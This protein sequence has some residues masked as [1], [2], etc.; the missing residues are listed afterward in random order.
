MA[1]AARPGLGARI[2]AA[3]ASERPTVVLEA[4]RRAGRAVYEE[5][6]HAERVGQER[7]V[8]GTNAWDCSPAVASRLVATHNALVLQ[9]LGEELLDAEYRADPGT[10]GYV[11]DPVFAQVWWWFSAVPRWLARARQARQNPDY[12]LRDEVQL[13]VDLPPWQPDHDTINLFVA[14]ALAVVPR[15]RQHAGY[16]VYALD[17]AS[18]P[19]P[20]SAVNNRFKQMLA[21][22]ESTV[23]YVTSVR[24]ATRGEPLPQSLWIQLCQGLAT[25][26]RVA[27]SPS[28]RQWRRPASVATR[29]R[30]VSVMPR[31][32]LSRRVRQVGRA[33]SPTVLQVARTSTRRP[34]RAGR[35]SIR[36][37]APMGRRAVAGRCSSPRANRSRRCGRATLIR[38]RRCR[39]RLRSTPL[40]ELAPS[41]GWR[42]T[43]VPPVTPVAPG[44]RSTRYVSR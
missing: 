29:R 30:R 11:P 40:C 41:C 13:P 15:V 5:V 28:S 36:G 42:S 16:A 24:Y 2:R 44:P 14:A 10:P 7:T 1:E 9:Q 22:A 31:R 33:S 32:A 23:D 18:L 12:D 37:A 4:M 34:C 19:P 35:G 6:A 17:R 38:P 25:Y 26:H 39:S 20:R 21:V 43:T 27:H 3:L 8:D